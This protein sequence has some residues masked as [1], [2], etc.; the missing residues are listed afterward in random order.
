MNNILGN[1]RLDCRRAF[2]STGFLLSVAG[3]CVALFASLSTET[4]LI[5]QFNDKYDVLF[6]Y[7]IA[8]H[9]GFSLLSVIFATLPFSTSF[10]VDWNNQFIRSTII[11]SDINSY[12]ISRVFTC[13]L[14]SGS[15]VALGY[16]FFI[17]ILM[18]KFPLANTQ[19]DS[20]KNALSLP[21]GQ[22]LLNGNFFIYFIV[23]LLIIFIT[24]SFFAILAL[25]ISIYLPNIFVT[26][27]SP[28]L[29]YYFIIRIPQEIGISTTWFHITI[30][31]MIY[32]GHPYLSLLY[33]IFILILLCMLM[34]IFTVRQIKRRLE[35]G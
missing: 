11:R 12:G 34:G 29:A 10:C 26:M 19:S 35:H 27:A 24:S 22:I 4:S 9:Q 6:L 21:F 30:Y 25:W 16:I 8:T 28:V 7:I 31:G 14:A 5:K 2:F 18:M 3:M 1:M 15:A 13:L 20:F 17:F 23:K 32:P 33:S